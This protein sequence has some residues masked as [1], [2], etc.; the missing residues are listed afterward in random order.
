M[1][2][3][4]FTRQILV[5]LLTCGISATFAADDGEEPKLVSPTGQ[6]LSWYI[7]ILESEFTKRWN[8]QRQEGKLPTE[9]NIAA[10]VREIF[11]T[12]V[13]EGE[14]RGIKSPDVG[15]IGKRLVILKRNHD[16]SLP[17]EY[18]EGNFLNTR[19]SAKRTRINVWYSDFLINEFNSRWNGFIARGVKPE[20]IKIVDIVRDIRKIIVREA[21]RLGKRRPAENTLFSELRRRRLAGDP[22]LPIAFREGNFHGT[23]GKTS[24]KGEPWYLDFVVREFS[25][26][27][28]IARSKGISSDAINVEAII[29]RIRQQVIKPTIVRGRALPTEIP[30]LTRLYNL[31]KT[32]DPRLPAEFVD[33]KSPRGTKHKYEANRTNF[34]KKLLVPSW[35]QG[36]REAL[37]ADPFELA[38]IF[39]PSLSTQQITMLA[40][41]VSES[42]GAYDRANDAS[43]RW[44][45]LTGDSRAIKWARKV[46]DSLTNEEKEEIVRLRKGGKSFEFI[47]AKKFPKMMPVQLAYVYVSQTKNGSEG[48]PIMGFLATNGAQALISARSTKKQPPPRPIIRIPP[49]RPPR[50]YP[51]NLISVRPA[52]E[53]MVISKPAVELSFRRALMASSERMGK[54]AKGPAGD[55]A[56]FAI[57]SF[58][59][60]WVEYLLTQDPM[61]LRKLTIAQ[62]IEEMKN[63][64][65]PMV[66]GGAA[67]STVAASAGMGEVGVFG[68]GLWLSI[69]ATE[70]W[71]GNLEWREQPETIA[72]LIAAIGAV[73]G[74]IRILRYAGKGV[75]LASRTLEMGS[76]ASAPE[77]PLMWLL[78]MSIRSLL[79]FGISSGIDFAEEVITENVARSTLEQTLAK[80][81]MRF[82]RQLF[83][84]VTT[85]E[86]LARTKGALDQALI[87][88]EAFVQ[89]VSPKEK[90]TRAYWGER[91]KIQGE[92]ESSIRI[93][94]EQDRMSRKVPTLL[95]VDEDGAEPLIREAKAKYLSEIASLDA[96]YQARLTQ[97]EE[98]E[99]TEPHSPFEIPIYRGSASVICQSSHRSQEERWAEYV[100][101]RLAN[102]TRGFPAD[103]LATYYRSR[104]I[105]RLGN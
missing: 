17:T 32:G 22:A 24:R 68:M 66:A 59:E 50:Q 48:G 45:L 93:A 85:F 16:S 11:P 75:S 12:I 36:N 101:S 100:E 1:G 54:I 103:D 81:M 98:R 10:I 31:R 6:A 91:K 63:V 77:S 49:D 80:R 3:G 71:N 25:R 76:T 70:V 42:S 29:F 34:V 102:S 86:E 104:I 90:A 105:A 99:K 78:G 55:G 26:E 53:P 21:D 74:G 38:A 7:P 67:G 14:K 46:A 47:A 23:T 92:L 72:K 27:W 28:Q 57:G 62:S 43:N 94:L 65:A 40:S 88:Y 33:R 9:I 52:S 96:S 15:T 19:T 2:V 20:V 8:L 84:S 18:V 37:T 5:I 35:F 51:Y 83:S 13:Q 87:Q 41:S 73:E 95:R 30:L 69:V 4:K 60:K 56:S 79:V 64:Y 97:L 39:N 61:R 82:D 44:R 89:F 58:A